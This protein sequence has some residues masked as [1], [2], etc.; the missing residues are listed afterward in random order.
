[1]GPVNWILTSWEGSTQAWAHECAPV[2]DGDLREVFAIVD[3]DSSGTTSGEESDRFI[4]DPT[5]VC[6]FSTRCCSRQRN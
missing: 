6:G 4:E 5:K 2:P 1:M 3:K